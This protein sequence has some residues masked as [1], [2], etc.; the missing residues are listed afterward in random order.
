MRNIVTFIAQSGEMPNPKA[1]CSVKGCFGDCLNAS[2][3]AIATKVHVDGVSILYK[4]KSQS[5]FDAPRV[6]HG[7]RNYAIK[8]NRS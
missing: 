7:E 4:L 3:I 8:K 5:R 1:G 6:F 2:D